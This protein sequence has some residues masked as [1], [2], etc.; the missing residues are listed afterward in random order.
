MSNNTSSTQA[1]AGS[2]AFAGEHGLAD[3]KVT[4]ST[5]KLLGSATNGVASFLGVPYAAPPVGTRRFALPTRHDRWDGMRD[6][7]ELGPTAPQFSRPFPNL[8]VVPLIGRGWQKGDDFLTANIWTPDPAAQNL[9]VMVFIHGG[10]FVVGSNNAPVSDGTAFARSGVVCISLNYRLGVEGFLPI[11]GVPTNLGLRDLLF[12]LQWVQ[13]NARVFGGDPANVTVFGESAGAMAI[14]DLI[15]SPLANGL[16]RRAIIQSGHGSMVRSPQVS[17]R[18]VKLAAKLLRV[19]GTADGFKSKSI[20]E[21]LKMLEKLSEPTTW[22]D[23]RDSSGH[24]PVFGLSRIAPVYGD[25]VLPEL[26]LAAVGKG[27]GRDVDLLIGTNREEM[28]LYFVPTGVRKSLRSPLA[29]FLLS[30]SMPKAFRTLRSYGLWKNGK[31]PGEVFTETLHNLVFRTPARQFAS[32]HKGRTHMYEFEWRSPAC[33]GELGACHGLELPFVFD[34]LATC[35]GPTGIVG[36][37]PPDLL[38]KKVHQ[39]W[40]EFA[41]NGQLGWPQFKGSS[42]EVL[43]PELSCHT[44]GHDQY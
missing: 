31:H 16:F 40:V 14:A 43:G 44:Q 37:N 41:T 18:V 15:S 4:I 7:T 17:A 34:T 22:I 26:P 32:A 28:N 29:I 42:V 10:A 6:A 30:R 19:P 2:S 23:L 35:T 11:P 33:G 3:I 24:D 20:E 36:E 12:A 8:D 1:R 21:C 9:P 25:D 38:A 5:G 39:I 27:A 13:E